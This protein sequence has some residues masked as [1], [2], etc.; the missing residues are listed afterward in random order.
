MD[1]LEM[2]K[3]SAISDADKSD[4]HKSNGTIKIDSL[5]TIEDTV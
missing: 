5:N 3:L 1:G 4:S 2:W